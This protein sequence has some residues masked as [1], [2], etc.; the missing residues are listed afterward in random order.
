[1][2]QSGEDHQSHPQFDETER[3]HFAI[4]AANIG[5]WEVDLQT[6]TVEL[7]RRCQELFGLTKDRHIPYSE[8]IRYIH[9]EDLES[10]NTAVQ[11]S[12]AGENDGYYDMRYRTIGA[13]DGKLRWVHFS[14][15]AY[16]NVQGE[17]IRFGGI[18]QDVTTSHH[19]LKKTEQTLREQENLFRH[20]TSSA[21]TGLWLSDET[22]GLTYLNETLVE[23][24]GMAYAD[25]LG[26]GWANAIILEDRAR[27]A[28]IFLA[29][30]ATRTHYDTQFRITKW[31]GAVTWCR[32]AGDPYY[33]EDGGFAGYA[34]F[35]MDIDELVRHRE[36]LQHSEE[37][38]RNIVEQSPM[39]IGL[40]RGRNMVVELGNDA[41]F[42]VWGK[43]RDIIGKKLIEALPEIKNQAFMSLLHDVY[44]T[45][46]PFFGTG[47]LAR[48]ERN[49]I[50]EDAYFNFAY[51]PIHTGGA[52]S[53]VM[54][55]ATDVTELVLARKTTEASA[56]KLK[57]VIDFAPAAIALFA[58]TKLVVEMPNQAFLDI[59]GK[60]R[61]IT[62]K[63]LR[64][65]MP[66]LIDQP[67]MELLD[68]V[69][70]SGKA[71][72]A[73]GMVGNI[74]Q[75]GVLTEH[76]FNFSYIPL[77]DDEGKVYAILDVTI[78]VTDEIL[79]KKK[80]EESEA[81][82]KQAIEV[83]ELATWTIDANTN[84][85]T[86][87][88]RLYDW[89]GI[90]PEKNDINAV[91]DLVEPADRQRVATA[92]Q[93]A[94][95]PGS[96]GIFDEEFTIKSLKT[97]RKRVVHS[98]GK[99]LMDAQ[100]NP[101]KLLGTAQDI[102]V[103][104]QLLLALEQEI[105]QRTQALD[106]SNEELQAA[107]E[108][109][110]I[111]NEELAQSNN[112]LNMSNQDLQQFAHVASHDLKEPLRKIKTFLS[113]LEMDQATVYSPKSVSFL[114]KINHSVSRM[115]TMIE[116]VLNYSRINAGGQ[117]ME[118]VSIG[119]ILSDITADLEV[120]IAEKGATIKCSQLPTIEGS[121][122]LLYQLFYNLVINAL[123]FAAADRPPLVTITTDPVL[124]RKAHFYKIEVAD[125]G[126][127]FDQVHAEKIFNTFTMLNTKDQYEGTGLGLALCKKIAL[128]HHGFIEAYGE[129]DKGARF[130]I[131]LPKHQPTTFL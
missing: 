25:L 86:F 75:D 77:V 19:T 10:V 95:T 87:S 60:G 45:G 94:M 106:A 16:F 51:T 98:Q 28:E 103:H 64:E 65:A 56:A 118:Q 92:I 72:E 122:I 50:L 121:P 89:Y 74:I 27:S 54:V 63:P 48:L 9:P 120:M 115:Q 38:F 69:Y 127:G 21:P 123:R 102:T 62:G 11:Q 46:K 76:Y 84:N 31:D 128:R 85:L 93:K 82:L 5:F 22:G 1:M 90:E 101:L 40:L 116:G 70:R 49:G 23:W 59:A 126:I 109:L 53:G 32:A 80:I 57:A 7:D 108:E 41:I 129:R 30:V 105:Q 91:F 110:A 34:G 100:S 44:D 26:P 113:R 43:S 99:T 18:A 29:A 8:A 79:N 13:S 119:S 35:C 81:F 111:T 14:G 47:S 97:G 112:S 17:A 55:L 73:T 104:R 71:Y 124:H 58:G 125:N 131:H 6:D 67:F 83:A 33:R 36:A 78:D 15:R 117:K 61:E 107:N 42:Q 20:V 2:L 12:L 39:A 52:V 24:T 66:E 37:R 4:R 3:L 114:Q 96:D 88:N 68:N 130:V